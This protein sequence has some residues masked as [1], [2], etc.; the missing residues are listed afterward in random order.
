LLVAGRRR[1]TLWDWAVVAYALVFSA[2]LTFV[3][4]MLTGNGMVTLACATWSFFSA[5]SGVVLAIVCQRERN[6]GGR[7]HVV[8][9]D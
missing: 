2:A 1:E 3:V 5:V 9:C 8:A 7:D 6:E 4:W